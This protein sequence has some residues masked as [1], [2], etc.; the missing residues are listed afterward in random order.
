MLD[1]E[2]LVFM[3]VLVTALVRIADPV[4]LLHPILQVLAGNSLSLVLRL[5]GF[6][7]ATAFVLGG[8]VSPPEYEGRGGGHQGPTKK[9]FLAHSDWILK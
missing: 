7:W 8:I 6:I 3:L 1:I 4:P 9:V 5:T 2:L